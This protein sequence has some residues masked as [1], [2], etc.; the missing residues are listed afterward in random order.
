MQYTTQYEFS[1][2]YW[3]V[4]LNKRWT[5]LMQKS[6][7]AMFRHAHGKV[8]IPS[9][10]EYLVK[11]NHYFPAID[12]NCYQTG[13][14]FSKS[15]EYILQDDKPISYF[16][17]SSQQEQLLGIQSKITLV[18][19]IEILNSIASKPDELDK[20]RITALYQ[21]ILSN[22]FEKAEIES[23]IKMNPNFQPGI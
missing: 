15:L 5:E 17:L 8:P 9:Y 23:V 11:N 18:D 6:Q 22:R 10:F 13:A 4:L 1:L 3:E 2:Q 19:C 16:T 7:R 14:I 20:E 12:G 21:Y